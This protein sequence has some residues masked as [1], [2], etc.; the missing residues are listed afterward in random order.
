M[1][2]AE[3][4]VEGYAQQYGRLARA[5][6]ESWGQA[7]RQWKSYWVQRGLLNVTAHLQDKHDDCSRYL[8]FSGC[9]DEPRYRPPDQPERSQRPY[10]S[11]FTQNPAN[12]A[13]IAALAAVL[14]DSWTVG[15]RMRQY[16]YNSVLF[17]RTAANESLNHVYAPGLCL[18][19]PCR[20]VCQVLAAADRLYVCAEK[21]SGRSR[22]TTPPWR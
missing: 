7:S 2:L 6:N 17:G 8:F 12:P 18:H 19:V 9:G 16:T 1:K 15:V 3:A 13:N 14:V 10:W 21:H 20:S 5:V 4:E 11:T 22:P